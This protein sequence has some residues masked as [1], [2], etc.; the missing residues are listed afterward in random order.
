MYITVQVKLNHPSPRDSLEQI[1]STEGQNATVTAIYFCT[2]V[3]QASKALARYHG[4][5]SLSEPLMFEYAIST[6]KSYAGPNVI[7]QSLAGPTMA[8]T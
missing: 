3:L 6:K 7:K 5:T 1:I 8:A 2:M 4:C